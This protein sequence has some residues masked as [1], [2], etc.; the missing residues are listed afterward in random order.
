MPGDEPEEQTDGYKG[1]DFE[2]GKVLRQELKTPWEITTG[3]RLESDSG[4]ELSD[5][6]EIDW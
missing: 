2:K 3:P 1:K 6:D 4:E 5:D